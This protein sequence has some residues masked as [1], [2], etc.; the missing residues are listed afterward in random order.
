MI[1]FALVLAQVSAPP[2]AEPPA[3]DVVVIGE[4]LKTWRASWRSRGGKTTCVTTRS[5]GDIAIDAIGCAAL[6]GCADQ[7]TPRVVA[8]AQDKTLTPKAR[9]EAGL[10]LNTSLGK[11]MAARRDTLIVELAD[12]RAAARP[13][14]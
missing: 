12:K 1:L 7:Y 6:T 14:S 8:L 2:A 10:A 11:C 3:T 9:K 13:G 4:K 5:S